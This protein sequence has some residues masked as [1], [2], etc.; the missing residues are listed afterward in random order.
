MDL[1]TKE[2][3]SRFLFINLLREI[4]LK[5]LKQSVLSKY[6]QTELMELKSAGLDVKNYLTI[7]PG[8]FF[9]VWG[10][11]SATGLLPLFELIFSMPLLNFGLYISLTITNYQRLPR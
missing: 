4:R 5:G 10:L 6:P 11:N 7:A 9:G 3:F 1:Y 8:C 2:A